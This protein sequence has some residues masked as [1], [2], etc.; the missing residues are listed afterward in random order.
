MT[1]DTEQN[2]VDSLQSSLEE[3]QE[4][5]QT[6]PVNQKAAIVARANEIQQQLVKAQAQL[7]VCMRVHAIDSVVAIRSKQFPHAHLRMDGSGTTEFAADGA[8]A[9]NCQF[10]IGPFERFRLIQQDDGSVAIASTQFANV[11]LRMDG[12]AV[13]QFNTSGSG[14]VNCQFGIGSFERFRLL[15]QGDGSVAIGSIQFPNVFL[16]MDG[17]GVTQFTA[18]G[19]GVINCQATI[20]PFEKFQLIPS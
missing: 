11:F 18:S 9:V 19:S 8:G 13:T 10:T 20:G 12:S 5:L 7:D 2:L 17:T 3:L 14:I 1:C 15:P 16:R 4:A 6:A